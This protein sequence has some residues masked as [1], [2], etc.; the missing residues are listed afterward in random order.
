[1]TYS[2]T[3]ISQYLTL[4]AAVSP[5]LSRWLEGEGHPGGNAVRPRLRTSPGCIFSPGRSRSNPVLRMVCL[6]EPRLALLQ[7][8]LLGSHAPARNH[9]IDTVLSGRSRPSPPAST[10]SADQIHAASCWTK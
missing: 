7:R 6:S 3:Q 9:A 5:S 2:Y 1:M 4:P 8:R 10:E